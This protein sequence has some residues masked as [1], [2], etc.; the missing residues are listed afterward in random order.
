[1]GHQCVTKTLSYM[2]IGSVCAAIRFAPLS[3]LLGRRAAMVGVCGGILTSLFLFSQQLDIGLTN[4]CSDLKY[5]HGA[6]VALGF[7]NLACRGSLNSIISSSYKTNSVPVVVLMQL[8]TSFGALGGFVG[9]PYASVRQSLIMLAA[10]FV[11]AT[12]AVLHAPLFD[13]AS[14]K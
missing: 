13:S 12:A 8:S 3:D 7:A 10:Y 11:F 9:V 1:M 5:V 2:G 6:A 14:K 4:H